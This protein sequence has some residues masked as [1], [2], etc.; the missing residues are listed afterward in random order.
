MITIVLRIDVQLTLTSNCHSLELL[1]GAKAFPSGSHQCHKGGPACSAEK[2]AAFTQN[3]GTT[4]SILRSTT[5][6]AG[7]DPCNGGSNDD[8]GMPNKRTTICLGWT[9]KRANEPWLGPVLIRTPFGDAEAGLQAM[10][11]WP[12]SARKEAILSALLSTSLVLGVE[13][14]E[15]PCRFELPLPSSLVPSHPCNPGQCLT[16]KGCSKWRGPFRDPRLRIA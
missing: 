10:D 7:V 3:K 2:K 14:K 9:R 16:T 12:K 1:A 4:Q 5:S 15:R 11:G 13:V 8:S 6:N